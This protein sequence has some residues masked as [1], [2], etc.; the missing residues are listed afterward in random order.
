MNG[1]R[2]Q[3][4]FALLGGPVA[5]A[6]HLF[7]GYALVPVACR[8]QTVLPLVALT[9]AMG[10][11]AIASAGVGWRLRDAPHTA[12]LMAKAGMGAGVLF[13]FVILAESA[14]FIVEDVCQEV[15]LRPRLPRG[16]EILGRLLL[17][18]FP[19]AAV[20]HVVS[21]IPSAED[22]WSSWSW[23]PFVLVPLA[24]GASA[25][26]RGLSRA[27]RRAPGGLR[28]RWMQAVAFGCG[29][30]IFFVAVAS[31]L[32]TV[33]ELLFSAHMAQHL[34]LTLFAAPLLVFGAPGWAFT[35]AINDASRRKIARAW[36]RATTLRWM[37]RRPLG[38]GALLVLH[39]AALWAWHVPALYDAALQ[40]EW[41]H[42]AEHLSFFGTAVLFWSYVRRC[43]LAPRARAGTGFAVIFLV[44]LQSTVL[45]ALIALAPGN[46][47]PPHAAG[48]PGWSLTALEDQQLAGLLMWVPG[49]VI[50]LAAALYLASRWLG[51]ADRGVRTAREALVIPPFPAH[52]EEPR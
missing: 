36:N 43:G 38:P 2:A 34:V 39:F 31:P 1:T 12:G 46:W 26:L 4:W 27:A 37:L 30:G 14:P 49:S 8:V 51:A 21:P 10:V 24:V 13:L 9:V 42:R 50:Y 11:V 40:D 23:D 35:W 19:N 33:G 48:A 16:A 32:H 3:L 25:Y 7:V 17:G 22:A 52:V 44:A 18:Q 20:A 5:W 28:R 15:E 29:I 45:G 47:Y 41:L 6:L